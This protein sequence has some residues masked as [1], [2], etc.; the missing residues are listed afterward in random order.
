MSSR[1]IARTRQAGVANGQLPLAARFPRLETNGGWG[2]LESYVD[3]CRR[4]HYD[5]AEST[6]AHSRSS[7]R[8]SSGEFPCVDINRKPMRTIK[9]CFDQG[10]AYTP[11]PADARLPGLND[12]RLLPVP[13]RDPIVGM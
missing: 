4:G 1:G 2:K 7:R 9:R 12:I 11:P 6:G 8:S 13:Q 3:F 10:L 5:P